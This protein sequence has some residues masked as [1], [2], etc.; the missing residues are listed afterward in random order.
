MIHIIANPYVFNFDTIGSM[1]V[2]I[3]PNN[4]LNS[5][6]TNFYWCDSDPTTKKCGKYNT[7]TNTVTT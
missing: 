7:T 5:D 2:Y 6:T 1:G 4:F 3:P